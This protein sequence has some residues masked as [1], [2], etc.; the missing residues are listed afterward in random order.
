MVADPVVPQRGVIAGCFAA[1]SWIRVGM[2]LPL[3]SLVIRCPVVD[4]DL[5]ID[6]LVM[7]TVGRTIEVLDRLVA[8]SKAAEKTIRRCGL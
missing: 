7:A 4:F 3:D 5:F 1:T 6:D 2:I 8:A